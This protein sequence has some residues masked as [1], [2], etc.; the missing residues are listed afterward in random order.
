[1]QQEILKLEKEKNNLIENN[2]KDK[3]EF[4]VELDKTKN[5]INTNKN[6]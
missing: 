3:E 1:M 2:K 4:E 5:K 6:T